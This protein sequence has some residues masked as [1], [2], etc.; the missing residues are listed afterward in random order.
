MAAL[1]AA[2]LVKVI[3]GLMAWVA[4]P[5]GAGAPPASFP[6]WLHV[7][8]LLVFA[9]SGVL[10]VTG[11]R[12]DRRA[13]LLG[14]I[15]VLF[16][17]M[18]A[19]PLLFRAAPF[20]TG[21]MVSSARWLFA[22]Q[23]VAFLPLVQWL[24]ADGFPR[25]E[26]PLSRWLSPAFFRPLSAAA[27]VLLFAS[28]L[29]M[30]RTPSGPWSRVAGP[31]SPGPN[32]HFWL[33]VVL[34]LLPAYAFMISK[35]SNA[36]PPERRRARLF[37]AGLLVGLVPLALDVLLAATVPAY[38]R[39]VQNP[40]HRR[41]LGYL[42]SLFIFVVPVTTG[43]AVVVDRVLDVRFI[44]R[45]AIQYALARYT[46]LA[47]SAIPLAL[48]V[49]HVY[50]HRREPLGDVF[51]GSSA[52]G[53]WLLLFAAVALL[54]LRRALL[55]AIDQ[56]FFREQ[57]DMRRILAELVQA[58]RRAAS[59]R[60]LSALVIA[61]VDRALHVDQLAVL[62]TDP[63]TGTFRDLRGTLPS[64]SC[65]SSLA[66]LVGG[67]GS[68]LDVDLS[69]PASPLQRLP[70]AERQWLADSGAQLLVPFLGSDDRLLGI[71]LL[72][73]K[74]S[75]APFTHEDRMLLTTAVASAALVLEHRLRVE[76][77]AGTPERVEDQEAPALQCA[78][79]GWVDDRFVPVCAKCG[80]AMRDALLPIVLKGKFRVERQLGAG[81]M[82]VVYLAHDLTLHRRVALKT[83]PRVSPEEAAQLRREA[84]SMASLDHANLAVIHGSEGWRGL[85]VL[86]LEFLP[87]GT[88]ADRIRTSR[89]P[90]QAVMTLGRDMAGALHH[91]H[92]AG[93]LHRDV[94]PSNIGFAAD[95]VPKLLDFGLARLL[96]RVP[97]AALEPDA[98]TATASAR[99]ALQNA[100]PGRSSAA[101]RGNLA[102]TIAYMSPEA[103]A[104][105][106]PDPSFDL[107]SLA[108]T[109][110]EAA[111][112]TNPFAGTDVY[113]TIHRVTAEGAPDVCDVL[114][115]CPEGLARFFRLSLARQ[116]DHRPA[117]ALEF[118]AALDRLGS[119]R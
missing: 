94:K 73:D 56:R 110:F 102:G 91:L 115:E 53:W 20:L 70:G 112:G 87:G 15:F 5:A 3:A 29:V 35:M 68:P 108:V 45:R 26:S 119:M 117:T 13:R 101:T 28:A 84:R 64:L 41:L 4:V 22:M 118:A 105:A 114:P 106:A 116:R 25:A 57:Y 11:G 79:C 31:L 95:G 36:L 83:L 71:L 38:S 89:L 33:V 39:F 81:G 75:D 9:A 54:S 34:L 104:L 55:T 93:L 80:G 18:F 107:W 111:T 78:R 47:A 74:R 65:S 113:D 8:H 46:V 62:V 77:G 27:G 72:G 66:T 23:P 24:F 42:E 92:R 48:M 6:P 86:V 61:E 7:T 43:Y 52:T 32:G 19:D 1:L 109:L 14:T 12:R 88:L 69:A 97:D 82:G 50:Q 2:A 10:L 67:A 21:R 16:A 76:S 100:Q 63:A 59:T 40:E 60:D 44:I 30:A 99:L 96:T 37:V 49:W 51:A 17:S 103:I 98:V 85:P 90:P 58:S